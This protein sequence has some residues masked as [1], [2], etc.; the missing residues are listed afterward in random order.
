MRRR[1]AKMMDD[2]DQHDWN[3]WGTSDEPS[4]LMTEKSNLLIDY[5]DL[6]TR[7]ICKS[8]SNYY[9]SNSAWGGCF[10]EIVEEMT[11]LLEWMQVSVAKNFR[12]LTS[13]DMRRPDSPY[14]TLEDQ[15]ATFE[16]I[17]PL[18]TRASKIWDNVYFNGR[19]TPE[20]DKVMETTDSHWECNCATHWVHA[21]SHPYCYKCKAGHDQCPDAE[22]KL[23]IDYTQGYYS[24]HHC[25][26]MAVNS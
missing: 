11:D 9:D 3:T 21:K 4:K 16:A 25:R 2:I 7:L 24:N 18:L 12:D 14:K 1:L 23:V 26:C 15:I 17:I 8:A 10:G 19:I 6:T 13:N 20:P 5:A 22:K